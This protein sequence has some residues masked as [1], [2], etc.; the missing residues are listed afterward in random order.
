MRDM[1]HAYAQVNYNSRAT[2]YFQLYP[3]RKSPDRN[4]YHTLSIRLSET[5]EFLPKRR[6]GRPKIITNQQEKEIL[7]SLD[8]PQIPK[9]KAQQDCI[10]QQF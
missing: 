6:T 1:I 8:N 9:H 3:N 10:K 7:M 4:I 2:R 5:G